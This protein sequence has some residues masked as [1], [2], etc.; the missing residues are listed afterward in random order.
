VAVALLSDLESKRETDGM[1]KWT[2]LLFCLLLAACA[3]GARPAAPLP[4]PTG[5]V[6][7]L[8]AGDDQEPAFAN[9]VDAMAEKL[10]GDGVD[11]KRITVLKAG[12]KGAAAATGSNIGR[13]FA[14]LAPAEGEGCFVFM[15]SHG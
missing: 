5:W 1:L 12:A 6:A 3:S 13:V 2:V 10:E 11:P 4:Q 15:T 8:I 9:A 14:D 7:V